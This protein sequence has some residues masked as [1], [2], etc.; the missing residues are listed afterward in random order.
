[1]DF[2]KGYKTTIGGVATMLGSL[3]LLLQEIAADPTDWNKVITLGTAFFAGLGI[4]GL[5]KKGE[6][7]EN[8]VN[9]K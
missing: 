4:F 3:L 7:I 6:R 9:G 2:L 1:M 5:A 8:A